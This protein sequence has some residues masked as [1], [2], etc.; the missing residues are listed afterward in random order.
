MLTWTALDP[1]PPQLD[2]VRALHIGHTHVPAWVA[3]LSSIVFLDIAISYSSECSAIIPPFLGRLATL[4]SLRISGYFCGPSLPASLCAL[5]RLRRLHLATDSHLRSLPVRLGR[6]VDLTEIQ[7]DIFG[8]LVFPPDTVCRCG[9]HA[10][11]TFLQQHDT[12]VRFLL[13]IMCGRRGRR[14]QQPRL[15]AEIWMM[16]FTEFM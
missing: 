1:V 8:S 16:V 3:D 14:G 5:T 2:A 9:A 12:P 10:I 15:P 7:L 4:R 6:L 13:L 11:K